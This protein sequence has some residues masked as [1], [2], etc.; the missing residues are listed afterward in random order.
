MLFGIEQAA[1]RRRMKLNPQ[2]IIGLVLTLLSAYYWGAI[3]KVVP[4]S[5]VPVVYQYTF[6][7]YPYFDYFITVAGMFLLYWGLRKL[8]R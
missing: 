3:G 4:L 6:R 8:R 5:S 2:L 1:R 7:L